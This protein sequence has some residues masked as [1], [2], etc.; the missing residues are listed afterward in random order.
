MK[1]KSTIALIA[2]AGMLLLAMVSCLLTASP[3]G[4]NEVVGIALFLGL[5][6]LGT[7]FCFGGI[8]IAIMKNES[9]NAMIA[10]VIMILQA[11]I[12]FVLGFFVFAAIMGAQTEAQSSTMLYM[13]GGLVI[14]SAVFFFV[15]SVAI[16]RG[17]YVN[18]LSDP[19][20]AGTKPARVGCF[21]L[22]ALSV[23]PLVVICYIILILFISYPDM[24][25]SHSF[26]TLSYTVSGICLYGVV[27]LLA[28]GGIIFLGIGFFQRKNIGNNQPVE[29][30]E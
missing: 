16:A 1:S 18:F 17:V 2:G 25:L 22:T 23:I 30:K 20:E 27:P 12:V 29:H 3:S 26:E 6:I 21:S 13:S 14:L 7:I 8:A 15:G 28:V 11:P 9:T 10:G 5:T 24:T 19:K 4:L